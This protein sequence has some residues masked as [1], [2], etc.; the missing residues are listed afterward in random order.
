MYVFISYS[1]VDQQEATLLQ[2]ELTHESIPS[3]LY[4]R[5][6]RWGG[7]IP[8]EI[9]RK[10]ASATH[11]VV[12]VSP[13]SIDSGWVNYELGLAEGFS[14]ARGGAIQIL[15]WLIYPVRDL[16][17]Y[18][19]TR[20]YKTDRADV[21]SFFK[22]EAKRARLHT[23]PH[24]LR[25]RLFASAGV[26]APAIRL[27][28]A[29]DEFFPADTIHVA[30]DNSPY[31]MPDEFLRTKDNVI[32]KLRALAEAEGRVFHDGPHT[33]QINNTITHDPPTTQQ[34]HLTH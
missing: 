5:D 7:D 2:R 27:V 34:K 4:S 33:R 17:A 10:I 28:G 22:S 16:P 14:L 21:L 1:T 19:A 32:T 15:P 8:V 31:V 30:V 18:L 23:I 20:R 29:A 6:L 3:Y 9:R 26:H 13:S 24:P 11:F 25:T 12:C